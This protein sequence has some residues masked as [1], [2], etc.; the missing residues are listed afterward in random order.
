MK[1]LGCLMKVNWTNDLI[2]FWK[3][4]F[5]SVLG[6]IALGGYNNGC[7]HNSSGAVAAVSAKM[8]WIKKTYSERCV[9]I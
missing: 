7:R 4:W 8:A 9:Q 5:S 6:K 3:Y 2:A 1:D